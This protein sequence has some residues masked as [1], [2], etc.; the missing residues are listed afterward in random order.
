M[1]FNVELP[2]F[3]DAEKRLIGLVLLEQFLPSEATVLVPEDFYTLHW[4]Q[5]WS[6]ILEVAKKN[7][8]VDAL[9]VHSIAKEQGSNL[10]VTEL[11]STTTDLAH[12]NPTS[13]VKR[14]QDASNRRKLIRELSNSV[15]QLS[16]G[17][18]DFS[19]IKTRISGISDAAAYST[20]FR[21]LGN[22]LEFDVRPALVEL[23]EGKTRKI[24]TGFPAIDDAIGGGLSPSDILVVAA[25]TGAGKSAFALQMASQIAMQ[26]IPVAFASGEMSDKENAL[27]LLSQCA[28]VFNLNTATRIYDTEHEYLERWLEHD[29]FRNLPL[30]FD[31]KTSDLRSLNR[32][33]K[34]FVDNFGIKV[35]V[36]DYIQLFRL[37]RYEKVSRVERIAEASQEVKRMAM[38]HGVAVI[39]VAQFNREGAKSGKPTMSDLE[40]SSQ[41]EK[42]ASLIF[43]ID[44]D[45]DSDAIEL[46]IVKGRN[47]AKSAIQGKFTGPYLLF[48]FPMS[49]SS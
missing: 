44:R 8:P 9:A 26:N 13:L 7:E 47:T 38:E 17:E 22:I 11:L 24:P 40:G 39:E 10:S 42:D 28:K 14:I 29:Q 19:E 2:S 48:D 15:N 37:D 49:R 16:I 1:E 46:R 36:I 5:A 20:S 41:L 25:M 31:S 45:Q 12:L 6:A 21:S 4:K 34:Y 43:I 30:Y 23:K 33:L 3:P 35:L 27:R 32:N 18:V